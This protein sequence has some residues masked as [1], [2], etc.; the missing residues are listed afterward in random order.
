M[1][2][3]NHQKWVVPMALL[4]PHYHVLALAR[5]PIGLPRG[6]CCPDRSCPS[7]RCRWSCKWLTSIRS[8]RWWENR[9]WC[10]H[11]ECWKMDHQKSVIFQSLHSVRGFTVAMVHYQR[12]CPRGKPISCRL[13]LADSVI[14][15]TF[16]RSDVFHCFPLPKF[17]SQS[18]MESYVLQWIAQPQKRLVLCKSITQQP[19]IIVNCEQQ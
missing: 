14:S 3:I 6:R 15:G 8:L 19:H 9:P 1:A 11:G 7:Q 13:F 12:V 17:G 16:G 18:L 5:A 10:Q 2:G 4:Y